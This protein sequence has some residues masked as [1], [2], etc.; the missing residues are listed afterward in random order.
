MSGIECWSL[1]MSASPKKE[2]IS[3]KLSFHIR[4][5]LVEMALWHKKKK[6]REKTPMFLNH[7]QEA[8]QESVIMEVQKKKSILSI[9]K[10][11]GTKACPQPQRMWVYQ[12]PVQ[13]HFMNIWIS[14]LGKKNVSQ[15]FRNFRGQENQE[16][17]KFK[18]HHQE[19]LGD[20]GRLCLGNC[21]KVNEIWVTRVFNKQ[22]MCHTSKDVAC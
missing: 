14:S 1:P 20:F 21:R 15:E 13:P 18:Q 3:S 9:H 4:K 17:V 16:I 8:F 22:A 10:A 12:S 5:K 2:S 7:N 6:M 19:W 11:Q